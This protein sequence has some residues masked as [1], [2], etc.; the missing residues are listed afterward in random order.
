MKISHPVLARHL[1]SL[2][3]WLWLVWIVPG[4]ALA[5]AYEDFVSAVKQNHPEEAAALLRRGMD[6]NTPD[7]AG[8]PVLHLAARDG[9]L[10]LVQALA[11]AG[12]DLDRKNAVGETAIMLA[13]IQGHKPVVEFL[14]SKEAQVNHPGWTPLIYAAASGQNDIVKI[15]IE[16]HAYIDATS[17]NGSTSLMMAV[18]GGHTSTVK[19][20]IDEDADTSARNELGESALSWAERAANNTEMIRL[21]RIK[22]MP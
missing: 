14:L 9:F 6:P 15:L 5:G 7:Q 8:M 21:L 10:A 22:M 11:A 4:V 3:L 13:A 18:R 20:L 2:C 19:L 16:N 12:A 1:T 17:P